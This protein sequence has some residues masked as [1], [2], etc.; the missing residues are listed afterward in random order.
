MGSNSSLTFGREGGD[1]GLG[2]R[3]MADPGLGDRDKADAQAKSTDSAKAG[4]EV[5]PGHL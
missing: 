2:D 1:L 3:D 5:Q 4:D